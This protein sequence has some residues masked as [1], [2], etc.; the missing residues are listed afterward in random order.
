MTDLRGGQ[1]A[2]R[3]AQA[4]LRRLEDERAAVM[5]QRDKLIAEAKHAKEEE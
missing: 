3:E 5:A 4:K 1:R 2:Q